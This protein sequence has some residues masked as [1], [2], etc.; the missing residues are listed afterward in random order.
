MIGRRNLA[1]R[2]NQ[3]AVRIE[4]QL[5]VVEGAAIAFIDADGHDHVGVLRGFADRIGSRGRD[6][7]GLVQ[8]FV[9]LG[10]HFEWGLHEGKI[11]VVRHDGFRENGELH[12]PLAE[13]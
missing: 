13:F 5:S 4:Q 7:D 9:V 12:A 6:N 10:A 11:R 2:L 3:G 8:Q 1:P